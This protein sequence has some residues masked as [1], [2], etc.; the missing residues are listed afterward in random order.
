[1]IGDGDNIQFLKA[2]NYIW[3]LARKQ[4]CD[5]ST[6]PLDKLCFP[7]VWSFSPRAASIIPSMQEFYFKE[8]ERTGYDT[9]VL[10]PSGDLYSYPSMMKGETQDNHVA[11][12]VE[13]MAMLDTNASVHW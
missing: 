1:M 8:A 2:R 9:F 10:P 12:T 4:R 13:D 6:G 7:L 5:A 3:W 11:R